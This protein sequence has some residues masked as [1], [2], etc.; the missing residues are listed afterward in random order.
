MR[1][2]KMLARAGEKSHI[3]GKTNYSFGIEAGITDES[4]NKLEIT[5]GHTTTILNTTDE[6]N[7]NG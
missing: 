1:T 5:S 7:L 3:S 4:K 6:I 2:S